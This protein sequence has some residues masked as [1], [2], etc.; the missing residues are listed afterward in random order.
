MKHFLSAGQG[1]GS[2][3]ESSGSSDGEG[4]SASSVGLSRKRRQ[5]NRSMASASIIHRSF[6]GF[7]G[8]PGFPVNEQLAD[9]CEREL[10]GVLLSQHSDYIEFLMDLCNLGIAIRSDALRDAAR[11]LLL[12]MPVGALQLVTC[13]M[14]VDVNY[15]YMNYMYL[16]CI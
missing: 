12:V 4:A 1:Y 2:S 16:I 5:R 15:E 8:G 6:S 11:N 14:R 9:S 7:T 10:P 13:S 3:A